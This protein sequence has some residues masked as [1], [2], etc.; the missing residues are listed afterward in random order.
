M[1]ESI[2]PSQ[3]G[4]QAPAV[5]EGKDVP[6]GAFEAVLRGVDG[7]KTAAQAERFSELQESFF[8]WRG[9]LD[10]SHP[11]NRPRFDTVMENSDSFLSIVEKAVLEDGYSDPLAFVRGL[12]G[13]ELNTLKAMHSTGDLN[14][15]TMTEEGALNLILPF[16]ERQDIDNDGFV[17]KGHGVGWTFPP[18][19]APESVHQAWEKTIEGMTEGEAMMAQA[20]FMP[21]MLHRDEVTGQVSEVQ[22]SEASNPYARADFSFS[23]LVGRRL[24]SV[25]AFRN[26]MSAEQYAFQKGFLSRFSGYLAES[27]LS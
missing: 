19:N 15:A 14:P 10:T 3:V 4:T 11:L 24:E 13:G 2:L 18:V 27:D 26:E 22:R 20:A 9:N 23:R 1:I 21:A 5:S 25:E 16:N 7:E 17:E 8:E 6:T 12:S